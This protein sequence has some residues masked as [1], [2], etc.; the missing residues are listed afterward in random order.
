MR[1]QATL[2]DLVTAVS[3]SARTEAEVIATVVHL[4]NSGMVRLCGNF[5]GARF[6]L[7]RLHRDHLA[8]ARVA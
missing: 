2:L 7:G 4:V 8:A 6:D 5:A 1:T 3:E